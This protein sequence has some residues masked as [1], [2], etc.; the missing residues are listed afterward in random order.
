LLVADGHFKDG[1]L[2]TAPCNSPEQEPITF[3]CS[4]AQQ[5]TYQLFNAIEKGFPIS[6]DDDVSFLNEVREAKS[7]LWMGIKI[8]SWGQFQEW[9]M[10]LDSPNDTHRHLSHLIGLYPG[11]A[12]ASYSDTA[13]TSNHTRQEVLDAVR[14]SLIHRGNG[15]GPDADSGWEKMWRAACWAQ[16]AD[17]DEFFFELSYG[18]SVNYGPNLFSQYSPGSTTFQI[19]ANLGYPA[20]VMNALIQAPDTASFSDPLNVTLLPALPKQWADGS[21]TNTRIRGGMI[22]NLTWSGGML[23]KAS[24]LVDKDIQSPRKVNVLAANKV[25]GSFVTAKG[26]RRSFSQ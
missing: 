2:V 23:S 20:V 7:K 6:G 14:V 8:G 26:L 15:T 19:D 17:A 11:Y 5:L 3:G 16:L 25:L 24:F 1:T 13:P 22:M 12:L 9:K 21:L 18:I 4:H 10:D